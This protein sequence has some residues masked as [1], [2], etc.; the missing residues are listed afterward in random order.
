LSDRL[1]ESD[2]DL[3]PPAQQQGPRLRDAHGRHN[4]GAN[5]TALVGAEE[6]VAALTGVGTTL[7]GEL[8]GQAGIEREVAARLRK[9]LVALQNGM[10][11]S[12]NGGPVTLKF[13]GP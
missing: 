5:I 2:G 1:V 8:E 12:G 3:R 13:A 6:V 4:H 11:Q 7:G 10:G 9:R